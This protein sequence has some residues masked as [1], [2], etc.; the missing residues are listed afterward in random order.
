MKKV[1]DIIPSRLRTRLRPLLE[2]LSLLTPLNPITPEQILLTAYKRI[3]ILNYE[4]DKL[5]GEDFL[6][7]QIIPKLLKNRKPIC[8][9]VGANLGDYTSKLLKALPSAEVHAFEPALETYSKLINNIQGKNVHFVAKGLSDHAGTESFFD[10]G[11]SPA[12]THASLYKEVFTLL[13]QPTKIRS[14]DV[15]MTT[16]DLYCKSKQIKLIDFIKIDTEGNELTVLKGA[17]SLIS[18]GGLPIIQ[19][20]F[21]EMNIISRSFLKDFYGFLDGYSFFRL[22]PN[23]L[24]PLGPYTSRNEIFAFQNILAIRKDVCS[25]SDLTSFSI[26][27]H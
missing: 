14:F 6:L 12:S 9:D 22:M 18:A 19:F 1:I 24:L 10:Y 21:N 27:A 16:I 26:I 25:S 20:E 11:D 3:G 8:F 13:H 15:E 23:G 17:E 7:R 2:N 5:S 4:T